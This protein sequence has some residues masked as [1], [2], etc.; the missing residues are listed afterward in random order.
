MTRT[1]CYR[2]T[3]LPPFRTRRFPLSARALAWAF[4]AAVLV[5]SLPAAVA[6]PYSASLNVTDDSGNLISSV[7]FSSILSY[8]AATGDLSMPV[9]KSPLPTGWTWTT[10]NVL[11]PTTNTLQADHGVMNQGISFYATG[12]TDPL[13]SYGFSVKNTS[14]SVQ[15]YTFTYGESIVPAFSG[16][17]NLYADIAGSVTNAVSGTAAKVLPTTPDQD[18]DGIPEI[19]ALKFSPDGG[20]TLFDAGTDVGPA[21]ITGTAA[22]TYSYPLDSTTTSGMVGVP[23]DY[24]QF[25][26]KFSLTPGGD[27]ASFSGFAELDPI[28]EPTTYAALLGAL[29]LGAAMLRRR[30]AKA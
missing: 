7:D 29:A 21:F 6:A 26:A 9:W 16:S 19:Q 4:G 25:Q 30:T 24:W 17:Y 3:G 15:N 20:A 18:G 8:D 28:P 5:S 14:G 13:L 2:A 11:D 1:F 12:S 22:H 27:V 10:V 23:V